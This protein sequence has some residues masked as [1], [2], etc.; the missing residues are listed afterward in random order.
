MAAGVHRKTV[1]D[2]LPDI[3]H[4]LNDLVA[5]GTLASL[6]N[7]GS[8]LLNDTAI[9]SSSS[10]LEGSEISIIGGTGV[11]QQRIIHT[12]TG[13]SA[14]SLLGTISPPW[15]TTPDSTSRYMI[16]KRVRRGELISYIRRAIREVPFSHKV[17]H[18]DI[19]IIQN[20]RTVN[21]NF[22]HWGAGNAAL[23]SGWSADGVISIARE[24][25]IV[26]GRHLSGLN[27]Y[28]A[29]MSGGSGAGVGITQ[30]IVNFPAIGGLRTRSPARMYTQT[31]GRFFVRIFDGTTNHDSPTIDAGQWQEVV[32]EF[33]FPTAASALSYEV[34]IASG[35]TQVTVVIGRAPFFDGRAIYDYPV[36]SVA[37]LGFVKIHDIWKEHV[38]SG[39]FDLPVPREDWELVHYAGEAA[40]RMFVDRITPEDNRALLIEG[41]RAPMEP[42]LDTDPVEANPEF[43]VD[44]AVQYAMLA[45]PWGERDAARYKAIG[46]LAETR[47]RQ[48]TVRD[49]PG[50]RTV[51]G[52]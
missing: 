5:A 51:P 23:P 27:R 32:N 29:V 17:P 9:F 34:R 14:A 45:R 30:G 40:I 18:S 22:N 3:A 25:S 24:E 13:P 31:S 41:H 16:L 7:A 46:D 43:I 36:P 12:F 11:G 8:F 50:S 47:K 4:Q 39:R 37:D 19:S 26:E 21:A 44:R 15:T 20:S 6:G 35:N 2:I 48:S 10:K 28:A 49:F 33:Q 1:E 42:S 38:V 52:T